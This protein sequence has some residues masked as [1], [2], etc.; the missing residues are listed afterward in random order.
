MTAARSRRATAVLAVLAAACAG[1]EA[2]APPPGADARRSAA[3]VIAP[4]PSARGSYGPEPQAT[5]TPLEQSALDA[6]RE[7]LAGSG[8]AP[9]VSPAL[10]LA[11]RQLAGLA[12]AGDP[13]P[14]SRRRVRAAL[15]GALAF[16]PAPSAHLVV[17][18]SPASAPRALLGTLGSA[19]TPTHAGAGAAVRD[20]RAYVVVLL[21]RRSAALR[22]FPREV[23]AGAS[24]AL[25]GELLGLERATVHVTSPAGQSREIAVRD[26]AAGHSFGAPIAF[27][28]R[29]RWVVE[30]LARGERG[31]EVAALLVVSCGGAPLDED[32][33]AVDGPDPADLAEAEARVVDALNATR[34]AHGLP[35][36]QPAPSLAAVARRHSEAMLARG[37]LAH[38]LPEDG[39]VSDRLRRARIAY[40]RVSENVAKGDTAMA[41]HR[42]AE[43]SPAHRESILS[44]AARQVGCGIARG[45]L[46][47]G[48][49]VVYLTE[50]FL[51][52]VEDGSQD[53][54]TP[55]ARVREAM[56]TER[57]RLRGPPLVS[58]PALDEL[59][60]AE[61]RDMLGREDPRGDRLAERALALGRKIA[62]ADAFVASKPSDAARSQNLPD[63]RFRRVGVGVAV[64]DSRRYGAGLLW[65][66]VVYTD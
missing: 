23:A 1:R 16:D 58:D 30:V 11:A 48:D 49:P 63:P 19:G 35:P 57:A 6:V 55:E 14:L 5:P 22:P 29:G 41:A 37:V 27:D 52:P 2:A 32:G 56:W 66:A 65:I 47:T 25:R 18:S 24:V 59:A 34:R 44:R 46:P 13:D 51:E 17:V 45:R 20:G 42:A 38:V 9:R 10:V 15:A 33:A 61:A 53:R 31:P 36:L 21:S 43:E 7:R 64:G 28:A 62:A 39:S 3:V 12:A 26:R 60:R 50:V 8:P 40:A 54:M 4:G